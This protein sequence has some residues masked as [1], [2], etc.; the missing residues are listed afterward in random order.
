MNSYMKRHQRHD[1]KVVS[2]G[3]LKGGWPQLS[4]IYQPGDK[5]GIFMYY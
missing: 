5:G 2:V 3:G 1:E 4:C